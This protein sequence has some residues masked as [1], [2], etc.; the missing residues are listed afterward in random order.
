MNTYKKV[1]KGVVAAENAIMVV[2][3]FAI[4]VLIFINVI[5]RFC[6]NYSFQFVD[7]FVVAVFVLVSL[8]G[9]ALA[10][11]ED[12]GL[13]GLSLISDR[14]TGKVRLTQKLIANVI[15]L[16]YC[17]IL[18]YQGFVRT[19][20]E[21]AQKTNTFVMHWPLWIFVSFVPVSG[22]FLL[23]HLVENT[24]NFV[25]ARKTAEASAKEAE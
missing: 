4:L 22:I 17:G 14:L 9:A 21:F 20:V 10:S 5:G 2:S 12:G 24:I 25:E 8:I 1:M 19:A 13:I 23:L 18:T 7:E 11:R 3:T 15:S 6:F 16:I